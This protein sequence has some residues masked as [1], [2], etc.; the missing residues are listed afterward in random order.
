MQLVTPLEQQQVGGCGVVHV[1][2]GREPDAEH[3][4]PRRHRAQ[5]P[6]SEVLRPH[7]PQQGCS[8]RRG[9]DDGLRQ[10]GPPRLLEHEDEDELVHPQSAVVLGNGE[11][12][13]P[14]R[15]QLRPPPGRPS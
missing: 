1:G 4:P 7:V 5:P 14:E 13:D 10:G 3:G 9:R 2:E 6:L 15:G 12:G 8:H 11:P